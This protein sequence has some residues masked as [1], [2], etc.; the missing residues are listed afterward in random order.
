M[1]LLH[2]MLSPDGVSRVLRWTVASLLAV[3]LGGCG[4]GGDE[5]DEVVAMPALP[6]V[7]APHVDSDPVGSGAAE[8]KR[9]P[10]SATGAGADPVL[11]SSHSAKWAY[12]QDASLRRW[13]ISQILPGKS[14]VFSLGYVVDRQARWWLAGVASAT[15][16]GPRRMV[17]VDG[18][19]VARY[20]GS[21]FWALSG[22][23]WHAMSDP[24]IR[25]D[26]D[27][28]E[29]SRV[30][31]RWYFFPAADGRW[32][33]VNAN[34]ADAGSRTYVYRFSLSADGRD[35][36][37]QPVDLRGHSV[38]FT[39]SSKE[40]RVEFRPPSV[41]FMWPTALPEGVD[42]R[43]ASDASEI[44]NTSGW[45]YLEYTGDSYSVCTDTGLRV[46][47]H[48]GIDINIKG[49]SGNGDDGTA[50]LAVA[51]GRV[52]DVDLGEGAVAIAHALEDGSTVW[53]AHRHMKNITVEVGDA[54]ERGQLIGQLSNVGGDFNAHL[55]FELRTSRHPDPG[56]ADYWCGYAPASLETMQSWLID[57][58]P[59]IQA[60]AQ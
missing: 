2:N 40:V 29:A 14:D 30:P 46:T 34:A 37:W 18:G 21:D 38:R 12:Y 25:S 7:A 36:A 49:T 58:L 6:S 32:Y 57:P 55:H 3:V 51:A 50:V 5:A 8:L 45:G 10:L 15:L 31:V 28:I 17:S 43:T 27:L 42:L 20:P 24:L 4:G 54:V 59:F 26:R 19:L 53:S 41:T 35:Y 60:R 11:G 39:A 48:P 22:S 9:G 52:T 23:T 1:Y 13:Y 56:R 33:I 47:L 44:F 16:D